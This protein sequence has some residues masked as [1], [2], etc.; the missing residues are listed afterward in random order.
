MFC[1]FFSKSALTVAVLFSLSACGGSSGS[2]SPIEQAPEEQTPEE[3][4]GPV[5]SGDDQVDNTTPPTDPT[6]SAPLA[7]A[8][9]FITSECGSLPVA[10][11][12]TSNS[13][14]A[15]AEL[16]VGQVVR[17]QIVPGSA[18][19]DFHVWQ[20]A[21]EPGSYHLVADAS[22]SNGDPTPLRLRLESIGSSS[23]DLEQAQTGAVALFDLRVINFLEITS[24]QTLTFTAEAQADVSHDYTLGIF[25]NGSAVP[26]PG[27]ERC[28]PI[29]SLSLD[30]TQSVTVPSQ[31]IRED[32]FWYSINLESGTY[33]L[34]A[35][36]SSAS[37]AVLGYDFTVFSGFGETA[38][39]EVVTL[40]VAADTFFATSD[41]FEVERDGLIWIRLSNT[42]ATTDRDIEFTVTRQ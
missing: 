8:A 25:S 27:F 9:Q 10:S 23:V 3:Q 35:S 28:L 15:P 24:A 36:T 37:I 22:L 21:L 2:D 39:L 26:S 12:A 31:R 34:D 5:D 29:T 1:R 41:T 20:V 14:D 18:S 4:G 32:N 13:L 33:R 40:G 11:T 6:D 38:S 17:A 19:D 42:A 16:F 30:S 7:G